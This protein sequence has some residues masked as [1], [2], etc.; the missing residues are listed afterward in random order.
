MAFRKSDST[1][2][3]SL[4]LSVLLIILVLAYQLSSV[5]CRPIRSVN[6]KKN[7][8]I[9][10]GCDDKQACGA[11][12]SGAGDHTTDFSVPSKNARSTY[13]KSYEYKLASGPSRRGPGH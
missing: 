11:N 1:K 8:I 12:R 3:L 5:H 10:V 4:N 2:H 6:E 7:G 9:D 13:M